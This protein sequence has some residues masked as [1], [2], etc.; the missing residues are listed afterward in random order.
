MK[1]LAF[2][3][4]EK[5]ALF[6]VLSFLFSSLF[7]FSSC[8]PNPKSVLNEEKFKKGKEIFSQ[9]CSSCH[10]ESAKG[11]IGPPL[12]TTKIVEAIKETE[13]GSEVETTI[14]KGK[15]KMPSFEK[16]LTHQEIHS[17]LYYLLSLKEK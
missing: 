17:L 5:I 9:N 10:G 1:I 7:L 6:F 4:R 8:A 16:K 13:E 12:N 11:K 15:G 2:K 14:L 3:L